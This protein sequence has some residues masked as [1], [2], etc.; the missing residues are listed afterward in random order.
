M[1]G[2]EAQEAVGQGGKQVA[3]ISERLQPLVRSPK[4]R[5]KST[6]KR[7]FRPGA[8]TKTCL[9]RRRRNKRQSAPSRGGWRWRHGTDQRHDQRY[10]SSE[11]RKRASLR[12]KW[13][14]PIA[15]RRQLLRCRRPAWLRYLTP[16][17]NLLT[18]VHRQLPIPSLR[19]SQQEAAANSAAMS[20]GGACG[21]CQPAA[22]VPRRRPIPTAVDPE[23]IKRRA[24]A[25][26]HDA[27]RARVDRRLF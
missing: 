4:D 7:C 3:G 2:E 5:W 26:A 18:E 19:R 11:G 21:T 17:R 14:G 10:P 6:R 1:A 20:Q 27:G 12:R 25:C 22:A 9:P 23:I 24:Q 13:R 16:A 15:G 8:R